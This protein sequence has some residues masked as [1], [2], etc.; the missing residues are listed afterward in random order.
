MSNREYIGS[1]SEKNQ[2]KCISTY[3]NHPLYKYIDW[4]A[5]LDSEDGNEMHFLNAQSIY[6]EQTDKVYYVLEEQSID[7][8]DYELCFVDNDFLLIPLS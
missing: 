1:L 8:V 2:S 6:D 3:L 5:F 7:G 4:E